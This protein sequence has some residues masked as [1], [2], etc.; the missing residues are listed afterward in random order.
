M[1]A[2]LRFTEDF[3]Q[4]LARWEIVGPQAIEIRNSGDPVH[5][6]VLVLENDGWDV[7]ALIRDSDTWGGVRIEG[8]VLFP[9]DQHNYLGVLYNYRRSATRTDFGNI[10]IKGNGSYLR[11]NP[12]RDGNVSRI[13]YEEFRTPLTGSAAITIGEWQHFKAEIIGRVFHFYVG[14]MS[15]PQVTFPLYEGSSGLVGFQP[16][17]VGAPVWIDN[18]TV[19]SIDR[20][21]YGGPDLP[22]GINYTPDSLL[23]NWEVVGPLPRHNDAIARGEPGTSGMWRPF[24]VDAR[25]AMITGSVTEYAGERTVAYFRT[26]IQVPSDTVMYFHFSSAGNLV[27]W[28]N[29]RFRGF[30]PGTEDAWYDFWYNPEHEGL[31]LSIRLHAGENHVVVRVQGGQYAT[32]GFFARLEE[33]PPSDRRDSG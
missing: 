22:R 1:Q 3:E 14:D 15:T 17:S 31:R 9:D 2:Q 5:G 12:H 27:V 26:T 30:L 23:T 21:S 20:M 10:Y 25:G 18:I 6:R 7:Y 24:D 8:D 29:D 33:I 11:V 16:R 19:A 4:D 32:G 13:L 28:V